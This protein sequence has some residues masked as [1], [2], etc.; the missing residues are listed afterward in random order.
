MRA[1]STVRLLMSTDSSL[2]T[3]SRD[4]VP[5]G[6]ESEERGSFLDVPLIFTS[7]FRG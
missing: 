7:I 5:I 3:F 1:L 4:R 6:I 2:L